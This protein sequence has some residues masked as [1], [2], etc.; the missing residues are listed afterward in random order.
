MNKENRFVGCLI[1]GAIGN[2]MGYPAKFLNEHQ[3]NDTYGYVNTFV[4]KPLISDDTQLTLYTATGLLTA[5]TVAT[6]RGLGDIFDTTYVFNSYMNWY[7]LQEGIKVKTASSFLINYPEINQKRS[8]G[9][10]S[11]AA[12]RDAYINIKVWGKKQ[13]AFNKS[14]SSSAV[15]RVAPVG[16]F[17]SRFDHV[18]V[19]QVAELA[20]KVGA[21]THGHAMSHM[22]CAY[23]ATLV[24]YL[25]LGKEMEEAVKETNSAIFDIYRH[26]KEIKEFEKI[27]QKA[28]K[29][30]KS[31][32]KDIECI[33]QIGQGWIAEEALAIALY[34]SIKYKNSF[35][36]AMIASINHNGD[37]D[38]TAAICGNIV[39]TYLGDIVVLRHF[40]Q[41]RKVECF[42]LISEIA[43]DLIK[44]CPDIG[45]DNTGGLWD[46]KYLKFTYP[47]PYKNV[48]KR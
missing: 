21:I 37:S 47:H 12:L 11:L 14:M 32:K 41:G 28:I 31:R 22:S 34:C 39:G 4:E 18:K 6:I 20:E 26:E 40:P 17:C 10:T 24:Y 38:T 16:L 29:L 36:D 3:I 13:R 1:G 35:V 33:H 48:I 15:M 27:L 43:S 25:A 42:N 45:Y 23:L 46:S 30:A 2:A 7:E 19:K 8:R 44:E 9:Y 5:Y